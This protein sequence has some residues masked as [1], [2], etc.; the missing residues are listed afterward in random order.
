MTLNEIRIDEP[1]TT[2]PNEY[3]ELK[4][5]PGT[6]LNGV[7]IVIVGD[8]ADL[9]GNVE[10]VV[11]LSGTAIPK[12]G[13]MLIAE[14][15]FTLGTPDAVRTALTAAPQNVAALRGLMQQAGLAA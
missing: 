2:D 11:S 1:G 7:S 8:G 3:I 13:I 9:N 6:S 12:D 4:G 15:T 10:A 14:S 5:A